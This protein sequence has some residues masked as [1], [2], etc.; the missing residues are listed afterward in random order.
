MKF[1]SRA[2]YWTMFVALGCAMGN[3]IW[4][5]FAVG[6]DQLTTQIVSWFLFGW[7]LLLSGVVWIFL[8]VHRNEP[9]LV[10]L[11]S[12]LGFKANPVDESQKK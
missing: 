12:W 5:E 7:A 1:W 2:V 4:N 9:Q 10:R 3:G 11:A 8:H 6:K